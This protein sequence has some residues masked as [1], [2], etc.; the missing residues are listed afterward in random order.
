MDGYIRKYLCVRGWMV[1]EGGGKRGCAKAIK[2][3]NS[4]IIQEK[5]FV[6]VHV[7]VHACVYAEKE[8]EST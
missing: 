7:C 6:C 1:G 8:R 3:E 2:Y 5:K 4:Q